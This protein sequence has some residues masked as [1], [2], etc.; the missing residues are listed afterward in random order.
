MPAATQYS[1]T[2]FAEPKEENK[3]ASNVTVPADPWVNKHRDVIVE[4]L[5]RIGAWSKK[6][7]GDVE[8]GYLHNTHD[9]EIRSDAN[10]DGGDDPPP[11]GTPVAPKKVVAAPPPEVKAEPEL[12]YAD[13]EKAK[14]AA[15]AA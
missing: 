13:M 2:M 14:A 12:S 3:T 7:F 9:G 10:K 15:K 6:V 4:K 8:D 5:P 1:P 11:D